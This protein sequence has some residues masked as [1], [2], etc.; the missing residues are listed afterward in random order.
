MHQLST[1]DLQNL[2]HIMLEEQVTAQKSDY[3]AQHVSNPQLKT[4]LNRKAQRCR[5][6]IQKLN[7]FLG[8]F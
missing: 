5:Q 2:R 7:Q 6:N 3:F 8:Q 1:T 4:H